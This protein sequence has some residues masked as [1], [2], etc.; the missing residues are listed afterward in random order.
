M[1]VPSPITTMH[2]NK[3]QTL[4]IKSLYSV[5]GKQFDELSTTSFPK[6]ALPH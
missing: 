1:S 4:A 2:L 6:M 5:T 3:E